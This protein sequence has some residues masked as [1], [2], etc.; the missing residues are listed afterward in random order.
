MKKIIMC[1][2]VFVLIVFNSAVAAEE[3]KPIVGFIERVKIIDI[4]FGGK[5]NAE[6][7][8]VQEDGTRL[9]VSVCRDTLVIDMANK[10]VITFQDLVDGVVVG[11]F[12]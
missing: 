9:S 1:M 5:Q 11:I 3:I 12:N 8:L 4:L 7:T 6:V 2:L 10:E